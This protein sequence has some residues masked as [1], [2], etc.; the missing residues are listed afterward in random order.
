MSTLGNFRAHCNILRHPLPAPQRKVRFSNFLCLKK[1]TAAAAKNSPHRKKIPSSPNT[2][3]KLKDFHRA[4]ALSSR[5]QRQS[6]VVHSKIAPPFNRPPARRLMDIKLKMPIPPCG[7]YRSHMANTATMRQ[8]PSQCGKYPP[9][10][11]AFSR[12][13]FFVNLRVEL[14]IYGLNVKGVAQKIK[15]LFAFL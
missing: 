6:P 11:A 2:A 9:L 10:Y 7:K 13:N 14:T 8:I 1:S 15:I 4:P 12:K 3:Q 5:Q